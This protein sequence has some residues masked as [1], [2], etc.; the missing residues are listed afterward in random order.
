MR[1]TAVF[2]TQKFDVVTAAGLVV[3]ILVAAYSTL[4]F[5]HHQSDER[6]EMAGF[7]FAKCPVTGYMASLAA[8]SSAFEKV[9]RSATACAFRSPPAIR[10]SLPRSVGPT[11]ECEF[12][13]QSSVS[14][15]RCRRC[16]VR[17]WGG[18]GVGLGLGGGGVMEVS[19]TVRMS[20]SPSILAIL[21][22]LPTW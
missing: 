4:V 21:H 17:V 3:D 7:L 12:L 16:A 2:E 11:A 15:W 8:S 18:T 5:I 9:A 20:L 6:T 1:G 10:P 13:L 22:V 14:E 19:K